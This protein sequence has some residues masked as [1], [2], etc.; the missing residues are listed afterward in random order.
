MAEHGGRVDEARGGD[1]VTLMQGEPMLYLEPVDVA[2][3]CVGC[4]RPMSISTTSAPISPKLIA[5]Q[6][7]TLDANRPAS[8]ERRRKTNQRTARENVAQLVDDGSFMEYGASPSPPS[9][10][11]AQLDDL[12]KNTPADGLDDRRW[13]GQRREI[14]RGGRALHGGGLRL[15]RAR[16]HAGPHEP[17]EDRP[18]ARSSRS[19]WRVPVVF[20][21]EGGGGRPGDTDRLGIT[22]L[23][24]PTFVQFARLSG[25][26]PRDR[27]GLRP[28]LRRQRRDAR[29][30]RRHH[31]H[32]E[33]LDR[34]GRPGD[35]R[36]RRAR[37]LSPGRGRAGVV[38]V[39]ERR[40]RH[41]GRGRGGGGG[42]RARNT[43]PISRARSTDWQAPTS[44]CCAA[45]S[46]RTGCASTTSARS[47]IS[48]ADK[49]SVLELRRDFGV[50]MITALDPHRR[51][52]VRPDRQQ[53]DA[54]SAARSM[55]MPATRPRASCSSATPSICRSSRCATRPASWSGP[56]A[57]KTA[58][59]RHVSRMFVTGAQPHR[60]AV[61]HRA[62][63]GLWPR[64]AVDDR[65][66]LPR[67]VL[68]AWPGRPASSAAWAWRA[69][70]ASASA[71]SWRRSPTP[72][73]AR[74]SIATRSPS[75]TPTARRSRSP[76]CSRSTTSS[77]PPR[78]GAGSWRACVR[79]RSRRRGR[80]R[81][82]RVSTPG[83]RSAAIACVPVP[84]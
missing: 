69:M 4:R 57:E 5:R 40:H 35:D 78:R 77:I 60:A 29:L 20:F 14:R 11:G 64:R 42:R 52:A 62:A 38:P 9:G 7:N 18:H 68:H 54:I 36:R 44:A 45:R 22:G 79:C 25:L 39:A 76:R 73:S 59:V 26:V 48:L 12:I 58:I 23:D 53:S 10:A 13:H 37:R 51:Q 70:S 67:L 30:L 81:S 28:L 66:R 84:D 56:E 74:P 3:R 75:S 17:Q 6:A 72:T 8:V 15:H 46:R 43:C 65:R 2:A 55:P 21:A 1:G 47:S 19:D 24:G 31:R 33:R 83:E 41:R 32:Q 34:H 16:R 82:G 27:H 71:R 50:G 61:R 80:R 63:Q 49:G